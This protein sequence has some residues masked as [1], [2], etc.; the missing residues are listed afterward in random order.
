M[1]CLLRYLGASLIVGLIAASAW[2]YE[3]PDQAAGAI[4][5][6]F[7]VKLTDQADRQTISDALGPG[8]RLKKAFRALPNRNLDY[9]GDWDR[10]CI[11]YS[12]NRSMNTDDVVRLLGKGN[13]EYV[14]PDYRI[15]LFDLP[16]DS[17]FDY[18][19][20][21]RNTGQDY[22]GIQRVPGDENDLLVFKSGTPG[23]DIGLVDYYA[24]P[25]AEH[26]RVVV[27]VVDSGVDAN[28][29]ELQ[30]QIWT[31]PDEIPDNGIDD[32]HNGYVDDIIG[33]DVSGDTFDLYYEPNPDNIPNDLMGHG[34]HVAGIIAAR[35]DTKGIV[36]VAPNAL[37]M[38]ISLFPNFSVST[39][40]EG[41]VYA[42]NSGARIINV[43]WGTAFDSE[44]LRE[45]FQFARLNNV[46]VGMS[47][48]NFGDNIFYSPQSFDSSFCVAASNSDGYLTEF[49][50]FGP[51]V[52][53]VAP[54]LDILSLRAD[55][56][57]LYA[58]DEPEVRI[59]D[60]DSLYYLSDGTSMS[61]P[62]V[63]G[64]AALLLAVRPDLTVSEV[65]Q[66]LRLGGTDIVDPL[67]DGSYYPGPDTIC[68]YGHL[69]IDASLALL[70]SE[71]IFLVEPVSQ[72]RYDGDVE[73]RAAAAGG[74]TGAWQLEYARALDADDWLPLTAGDNLPTDSVI[75][76]LGDEVPDG[77]IHLRLTDKYG[78]S[79]VVS[80][81]HVSRRFVEITAP[82]A[83][84]EVK[85][86]LNICGSAYGPDFDSLSITATINSVTTTLAVLTKECFDSIFYTWTISG[87]DT[88]ACTIEVTGHYDGQEL[89]DAVA[90]HVASAFAPGWP[91]K[92]DG[93]GGPAPAS[94]DLNRDGVREVIVTTST[95]VF[96]FHADGTPVDGF[97]VRPG[98][99]MRSMPAIYDVDR[100][101]QDEIICTG[102]DGIHVFKYDGTYA[103]GWPQE[104]YTG[105]TGLCY[106][107]PVVALLDPAADSAIIIL[108]K[109]GVILAYEFDGDSYFYSLGGF[110]ATF[111]LTPASYYRGGSYQ[112]M[113]TAADFNGDGQREVL[114]AY[115]ALNP[116]CGLG[117]FEGRT[118]NPA[119]DPIDPVVFEVFDV[120]GATLTDLNGDSLPEVVVFGALA[121]DIPALWVRTS[122]FG[123]HPG[124]PV[125]FPEAYGWICTYPAAADLDLDGVPEI[126]CAANTFG[127]S[128]LYIFRADGTPYRQLPDHPYGTA[129]FDLS[130][131]STPVVGNLV[132]DEYPEI[133]L[134]TGYMFPGVGPERIH[135]LDY[136]VTPIPG[137]PVQTLAP[138]Y[139]AF[140]KYF[141]PLIDDIDSDGYME[142]LDLSFNGD[143]LCWDFDAEYKS[144][145]VGRFL[146]D[147][148]N[149]NIAWPQY[150]ST[151]ADWSDKP[152]PSSMALSQ[153]YP[154]PFNPVTRIRFDLPRKAY[155]QLD[156][157]NILGQRVTSLVNREMEAGHH[158]V[159][160]DGSRFA[161]GL[162]LYRLSADHENITKKMVLVK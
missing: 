67:N 130:E 87:S 58:P 83:G 4:P 132:G 62:I 115:T 50:S 152:L 134:F 89:S 19:W 29:P 153:N 7:I 103:D 119:M 99:D 122:S 17:L 72:Q 24:S 78:K 65:E 158:V 40:V 79:S 74:Y 48:G 30:G 80:F 35:A 84:V 109:N 138:V 18:Q 54:G 123:S 160:F 20:Y 70:E 28:H 43:S 44:T 136:Q 23:F 111:N 129:Y 141:P 151:D 145:S 41:V 150:V 9:P 60:E 32:D 11:F 52:D 157:Y 37:I 135:I 142:L 34:T 31:N 107:H 42:V 75:Y 100:D 162:Y 88:G 124:W 10:F 102:A 25:P 38:A 104:C 101:G 51:P 53:I 95:G 16:E 56:T 36:G 106:P 26:T 63:C 91:V 15:E 77:Y 45:A 108:N 81:Y 3:G 156:V 116:T 154:N 161:S 144:E 128:R 117:L 71:G 140:S 55:S 76:A 98:V 139:Q 64:A 148:L 110:F 118:G 33:W 149:S 57:D 105:Q 5:G 86:G 2:S 12:E 49:S 155:V 59:V 73:V 126:L 85:Y 112:P 69:N 22:L 47:A 159:E 8:N 125:V 137:S 46:F 143:L 147:N 27:A 39:A 21:L 133:V 96:A 114:A 131:F 113:V 92:T 94:A 13:I 14:E 90:F 146:V 66:A 127:V 1:A 120:Y 82:E 121:E 97:P 6:K 61:A 68:G 93:F